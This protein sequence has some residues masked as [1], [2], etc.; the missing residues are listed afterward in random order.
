MNIEGGLAVAIVMRSERRIA[1]A[2]RMS[3]RSF[4]QVFQTVSLAML[5]ATLEAACAFAE[6]PGDLFRRQMAELK[7]YCDGR[8]LSPG[9]MTCNPLSFKPEDPLSTADGRLAHSITLPPTVPPKTY[10]PGM[11]SDAYFDELCHEAGEFVFKRVSDVEGVMQLRARTIATGQMQRDLYVLEDPYGYR[12]WEAKEPAGFYVKPNRYRFFERPLNHDRPTEEIERYFGYDGRNP[13]TMKKEVAAAPQS[14]YGFIWRGISRPNDREMGIAGGE[15]IIVDIK[16]FEVLAV[17][18][19]FAR[20]G[21]VRR[22]PPYIWWP[23]AAVCPGDTH[24]IYSLGEFVTKVL[25]PT[26][27]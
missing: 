16:S 2:K 24:T 14:K 8:R 17:K 3:C 23:T 26:Q 25:I 13:Q 1:I 11:T 20:T 18:R 27:R 10:R 19:G 15:L 12:D 22:A 21:D 9:E 4:V 7:A 5:V 6:T